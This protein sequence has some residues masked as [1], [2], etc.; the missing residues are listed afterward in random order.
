MINKFRWLPLTLILIIIPSFVEV[1]IS[2]PGFPQMENY[3]H[4]S[5]A[6]IQWTLGINFLGLCLFTLVYGPLSDV[7]GRRKIILFG[8]CLFFM[9]SMG[10][11]LSTS[12]NSL[13][14]FRV[15][16]GIGCSAIWVIGFAVASDAYAGDKGVR[17]F[18]LLGSAISASITIAP[19][20][21]SFIV[22]GYGWRASYIFTA[23]LSFIA[24][25]MILLCLPETNLNRTKN[26]NIRI[27][28]SDYLKLITNLRYMSYSL[29][30]SI[31]VSALIVF[32]SAIPFLYLE[33]FHM[34]FYKYA[35][36]Q[37]LIGA[38][39]AIFGYYSSRL[40]EKIGSANCIML[41]VIICL[42]GNILLLGSS[43]LFPFSPTYFTTSM[44]IICAGSSIQFNLV[45]AKSLEIFPELRGSASSVITFFRLI[46]FTLSIFIAAQFYTGTLFGTA[47][48][49]SALITIGLILSLYVRNDFK[50]QANIVT[51]SQHE[52]I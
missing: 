50:H 17:I 31:L 20:V 14:I 16:Q 51:N 43:K 38:V 13:Y 5:V 18:A 36:Y 24:L 8:C 42:I 47:R 3:F 25:V 40:H 44:C 35:F 30:P 12:L 45:F 39:L 22:A 23:M 10:C 37:A 32:I 41:S 19:M 1:D 2:L 4:S 26:T 11:A 33:Y 28:C 9:G 46:L 21:G 15:L 49:V 6:D 48:I 27:I 34:S 52:Y 7:F 29:T